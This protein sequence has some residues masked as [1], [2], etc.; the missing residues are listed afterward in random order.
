LIAFLLIPLLVCGYILLTTLPSE[1]VRLSLYT[2]WSLYLRAATYGFFTFLLTALIFS[3]ILPFIG[4][5]IGIIPALAILPDTDLIS[6]IS[7]AIE[8]IL[9]LDD[10]ASNYQLYLYLTSLS[11][12]T[13][14]L[15]LIFN[16]TINNLPWLKRKSATREVDNIEKMFAKHSPLEYTLFI[17]G[18]NY[19]EV[20]K[21]NY[22][23]SKLREKS[24]EKYK[25]NE[26]NDEEIRKIWKEL[27]FKD[28]NF[29]LITL[30]NGKFYIGRPILIPPPDEESIFSS[31]IMLMPLMSGYRD[32]KQEL[33]F[34]TEYDFDLSIARPEDSVAFSVDK[35]LTVSGFNFDNH[36]R[37]KKS[38]SKE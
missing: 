18:K 17:I 10:N 14:T 12:I 31:S 19:Q 1:K 37:F 4:K 25:K 22:Q 9:T 36:Q 34:T 33:V 21:Y 2:G 29:A 15:L 27:S 30:E 16:L 5:L 38:T 20:F 13:C 26:I 7:E 24:Y 6:V 28:L 23:I 32:T 3:V 11:L 35:I 8:S